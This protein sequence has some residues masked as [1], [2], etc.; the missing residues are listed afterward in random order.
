MEPERVNEAQVHTASVSI[1]EM[2]TLLED[3]ASEK[4]LDY[5]K[6]LVRTEQMHDYPFPDPCGPP[7]PA[8][9]CAKTLEGHTE[10]V[11]LC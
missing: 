11:V 1:E 6:R 2:L 3:D 5:Y 7:N 9:P 4:R 10:Y 8:Q